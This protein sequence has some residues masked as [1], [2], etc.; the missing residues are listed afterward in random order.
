[1]REFIEK[2]KELKGRNIRLNF[3]SPPTA[4]SMENSSFTWIG[5]VEDILDSSVLV[6][7]HISIESKRMQVEKSY[8]NLSAVVIWA[9]DICTPDFDREAYITCPHCKG[10]IRLSLPE[11]DEDVSTDS[12][13]EEDEET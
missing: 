10:I 11:E 7:K 3:F 5:Q 9:I 12:E 13:E 2:L 8:L 4:P 1:M 6:F